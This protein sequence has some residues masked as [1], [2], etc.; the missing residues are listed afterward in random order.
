MTLYGTFK[1]VLYRMYNV[2]RIRL[3]ILLSCL[4]V[5]AALASATC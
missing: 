3:S 2:K 4:I 1:M 5:V